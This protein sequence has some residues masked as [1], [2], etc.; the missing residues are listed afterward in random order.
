MGG[1]FRETL[2][3]ER[4]RLEPDRVVEEFVLHPSSF[5]FCSAMKL[6]GRVAVGVDELGSVEL[7]ARGR[8]FPASGENVSPLVSRV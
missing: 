2:D 7:S 3:L 8:M 6:V 1:W 5:Y 4:T